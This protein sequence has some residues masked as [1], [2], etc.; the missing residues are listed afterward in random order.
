VSNDPPVVSSVPPA[1]SAMQPSGAAWSIPS[2]V[3]SVV[4][5]ASITPRGVDIH[6]LRTMAPV[7][8][9]SRISPPRPVLS[10]VSIPPSESSMR[11]ASTSN[12]AEKKVDSE[13]WKLP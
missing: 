4:A 5:W 2:I 6:P 9:R 13:P 3:K 7:V 12:M 10:V 11:P 8:D 1:E